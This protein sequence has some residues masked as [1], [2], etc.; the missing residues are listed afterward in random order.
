MV[1]GFLCGAAFLLTA[2]KFVTR[3]LPWRG[4]DALFRRIHP[5]CAVGFCIL[6]AIH[7]ISSLHLLRQRPL[8]LFVLGVALLL[9]TALAVLSRV[10]ASKLHGRWLLVHR[11]T[12][13][14]I[15]VCL[16]GHAGAGLYSLA[17]YRQSVANM[18]IEPMDFSTVA[19]GTYSGTA[20]VGYISA[21]VQVV[22][23]SGGLTDIRLLEHLTERGQAAERIP[24]DV[25][26]AQSLDVDVITG[27]TNSSKVILKAIENALTQ[28]PS[29]LRPT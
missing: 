23:S 21:S 10:F 12:S 14:L 2:A 16:I 26:N 11:L 5:F 27:A 7:S 28:K 20:S 1:L 17:A 6:A 9:C 18:R 15:L 24:N 13:L 29:N 8:F 19:D 22:V 4:L 25:L 3:R